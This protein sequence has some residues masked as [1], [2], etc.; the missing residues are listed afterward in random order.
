MDNFIKFQSKVSSRDK[1]LRLIQFI[2]KL[3]QSNP[4]LLN[5]IQTN[6]KMLLIFKQFE[7]FKTFRKEF[8][9][10]NENDEI[11]SLLVILGFYMIYLICI[12]TIK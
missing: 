6:R 10:S 1:T 9:L 7:F 12:T 4:I 11:T 5:A 8:E 3:N 2:T